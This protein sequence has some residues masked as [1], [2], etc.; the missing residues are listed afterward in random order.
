MEGSHHGDVQ[1]GG[2]LQQGLH[3]GAKLAHDVQIVAAG[4]FHPL[5]LGIAI[6]KAS[7]AIGGEQHLLLGLIGHH[8]LRPVHH[9]C[10]NEGE[11]V[12]TQLHHVALLD[13]HSP[14]G[15]IH[16]SELLEH[17]EGLG[18]A[19]ELHLGITLSHLGHTTS[20]VGLH[21]M[22][23]QVVGLTIA[24]HLVQVGQ[25]LLGLAGVHS[26]Q[27][28]H[29]LVHDHIGVVGNALGHYILAFKQ[30]NVGIIAADSINRCRIEQL[31][32][33][34]H[35]SLYISPLF[36]YELIPPSRNFFYNF[37]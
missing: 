14:V 30:V 28:G 21:V 26:V 2:L 18:V 35:T 37:T 23:H 20:V 10:H 32:H 4:L 8:G 1:A 27:N 9:G 7:E 13:H 31:I 16:T 12:L 6:A 29:L 34:D 36:Y 19:N 24:Q 5:S 11:A 33:S 22:H 15:V 17:G 3:L 25:P